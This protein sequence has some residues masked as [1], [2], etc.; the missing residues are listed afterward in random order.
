MRAKAA[1]RMVAGWGRLGPEAPPPLTGVVG[2]NQVNSSQLFEAAERYELRAPR[3]SET[4]EQSLVRLR[5]YWAWASQRS[6]VTGAPSQRSGPGLRDYFDAVLRDLDQGAA[7][8]AAERGE[9][10]DR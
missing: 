1:G 3:P 10:V 7:M 9:E 6:P 4:P 5:R 8:K 2:M